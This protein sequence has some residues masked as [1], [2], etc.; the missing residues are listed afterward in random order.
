VPLPASYGE[1]ESGIEYSSFVPN[2]S[3][4][5]LRGFLWRLRTKYLVRD[6]HPFVLFYGL[7]VVGGA[8]ALVE[9]LRS[10][11]D[12]DS[13]LARSVAATVLLLVSAALVT[14]GMV[15]DLLDNED[16]EYRHEK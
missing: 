14:F 3:L 4:L 12:S 11:V 6:C 10:I 8:V 13:S 5:L 2:L 15:F 16:L 1:E 9:T 7:G